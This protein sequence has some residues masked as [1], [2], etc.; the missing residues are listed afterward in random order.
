MVEAVDGVA[1]P[2]IEPA[3]EPDFAA[4]KIE[5]FEALNGDG[6]EEVFP[7][8]T[9]LLSAGLEP[10]NID[11]CD[12]GALGLE[13]VVRR[14][15]PEGLSPL[16][17]LVTGSFLMMAVV[18]GV[19]EALLSVLDG[20]EEEE[21]DDAEALP[22]VEAEP[23]LEDSEDAAPKREVLFVELPLKTEPEEEVGTLEVAR[24]KLVA[25][26]GVMEEEPPKEES[27]PLLT[28]F[29]N[30]ETPGRAGEPPKM[31][32]PAD[33]LTWLGKPEPEIALASPKVPELEVSSLVGVALLPLVRGAGELVFDLDNAAKGELLAVSPFDPRIEE[34][35]VEDLEE[36]SSLLIISTISGV[37]DFAFS[38]FGAPK[39]RVVEEV[40][41]LNPPPELLIGVTVKPVTEAGLPK[42]NAGLAEAGLDAAAGV[43]KP[44]NA[45]FA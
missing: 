38:S 24:E 45:G 35:G 4:P 42:L 19:L 9:E 37:A 5:A 13:V 23:P 20:A 41:P 22:K 32:V 29:P 30:A 16:S 18:E 28:T 44:G 6:E 33:G 1:A 2:N 25:A 12:A 7:P 27:L 40:S 39:L 31:E 11:P 26:D 14:R 17:E 21:R 43:P 36:A 15:P 3:G 10:P 34:S 8:K